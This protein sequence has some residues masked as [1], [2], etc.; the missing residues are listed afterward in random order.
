M[1]VL[2]TLSV[3]E[4]VVTIERPGLDLLPIAHKS[5]IPHRERERERVLVSFVKDH[6]GNLAVS[7]ACS[8]AQRAARE[9]P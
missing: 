9:L 6:R 4:R 5:G 7:E 3:G 1:V 2:F 8:G